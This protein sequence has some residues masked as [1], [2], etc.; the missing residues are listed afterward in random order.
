[1]KIPI[2]TNAEK[3]YKQIVKLLSEFAPLDKLFPRERQLL[4]L[5]LYQNYLLRDIPEDKRNI[6]LFSKDMRR[7]MRDKLGVSEDYFNTNLYKLK[8]NGIITKDN[9]IPKF[10]SRILPKDKFEFSIIFNIE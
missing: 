3:F 6:L 1:M 5:I 8:K 7:T 10:F 4:A 2:T 9:K